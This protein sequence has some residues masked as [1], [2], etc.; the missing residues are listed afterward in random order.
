M[1]S[2][3]ANICSHHSQEKREREREGEREREREREFLCVSCTGWTYI[4]SRQS[5]KMNAGVVQASFEAAQRDPVHAKDPSLTAVDITPGKWLSYQDNSSM[6]FLMLSF[7]RAG[8]GIS[9]PYSKGDPGGPGCL[10]L[11]LRSS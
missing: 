11:C 7:F 2:V 1:T 3:G 4:Q 8:N 9:G 6:F 10:G 5:V